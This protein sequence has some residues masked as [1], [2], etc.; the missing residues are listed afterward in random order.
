MTGINITQKL[1]NSLNDSKDQ[2]YRV[3]I[4]AFILDSIY[5]VPATEAQFGD[6]MDLCYRDTFERFTAKWTHSKPNIMEFNQFLDD[7]YGLDFKKNLPS[8]LD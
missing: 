6:L 5:P 1:L 8:L 7:I 4:D 3:D 2:V